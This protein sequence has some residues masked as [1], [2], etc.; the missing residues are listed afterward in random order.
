MGW[1]RDGK[2]LERGLPRSGEVLAI[3]AVA[4]A[5]LAGAT[6]GAA[7]ATE[8]CYGVALA[9]ENDGIDDRE[10]PGS[11][12]VDY[13]GNAWV[14]VAAGTCLTL[15]LPPAPDGTPRRGSLEPLARDP[16]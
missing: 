15:P 2:Q 16:G 12:T 9:G 7:Q 11:A 3:W 6:P 4:L 13:Q 1:K 10:A 8:R 5:A 14:A